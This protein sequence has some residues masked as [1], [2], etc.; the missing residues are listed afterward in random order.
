MELVSYC[1]YIV[2]YHMKLKDTI[3]ALLYILLILWFFSSLRM[4]HCQIVLI[5]LR[6]NQTERA[7]V[8][9]SMHTHPSAPPPLDTLL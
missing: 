2:F 9:K 5:R 7:V 4:I 3:F 8:Y 1:I 6:I